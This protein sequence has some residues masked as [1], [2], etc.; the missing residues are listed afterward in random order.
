MVYKRFSYPNAAH[1]RD[2]ALTKSRNRLSGGY[3]EVQP[4]CVRHR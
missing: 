1:C 2:G 4:Y 3:D